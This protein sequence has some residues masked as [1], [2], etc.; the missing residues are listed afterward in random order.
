MQ[1]EFA[2]EDAPQLESTLRPGESLRRLALPGGM[3]WYQFLRAPRR[4]LTI[5]VRRGR[6]EV[7]APRWIPL[8]D[9]ERF[10]REKEG[11]VRRRLS[12]TRTVVPRLSWRE[13]ETIPV[14][15]E[16]LS[17]ALVAG[18]GEARR[19]GDRI[20]V[21]STSAVPDR[22]MLRAAVLEWLGAEAGRVFSERIAHFA[23]RL[24]VPVPALRLSNA[25]TQWGSAS[26]RGRVRLNWRLIHVPMRLV[27]YVV[28]HEL[29]HL[30]EMNHSARFWAIVG[31]VY[32]GYLAAR[33]ELNRLEKQLPQI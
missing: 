4:T 23:P 30:R 1:L 6:V 32:P 19:S 3:L 5:V 24:G 26:A 31:S 9:V 11:W 10:V 2:L 28:V 20:E 15:G 21:P 22:A 33:R 14:L 13:G 27:D 25:R 17:L 18:P 8:A 16:A 29:S 12:D 7:R